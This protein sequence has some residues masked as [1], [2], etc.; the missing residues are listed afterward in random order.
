MGNSPLRIIG[1]IYKG[2]KLSPFRGL[3]IRPPLDRIKESIFD[4]LHTQI[5]DTVVLDLFAGT[6][7]L[8]IEA[9]SRGAKTVVFV[10]NNKTAI[11]VLKRN[12]SMLPSL[13]G[14]EIIPLSVEKGL[15]I[16]EKRDL[17]FDIIFLDPPYRKGYFKKTMNILAKSS[18]VKDNSIIVGREFYR[19][20]IAPSYGI[21]KVV[22]KRRYGDT[23][24]FFIKKNKQ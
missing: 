1:G 10:E 9:L 5:K 20:D 14:W 13:K 8:G 18:L 19:E 21:L 22:D 7:S 12:L 3:N 11:S 4:I 23:I 16:L 17:Q 6:G 15:R 24:V 2:K